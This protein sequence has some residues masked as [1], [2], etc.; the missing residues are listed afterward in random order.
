VTGNPDSSSEFRGKIIDLKKKYVSFYNLFLARERN[1]AYSSIVRVK[2]ELDVI[3]DMISH[4]ERALCKGRN[5][6]AVKSISLGE[7]HLQVVQEIGNTEQARN[8]MPLSSRSVHN[9]NDETSAK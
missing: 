5:S 4:A 1:M 9:K 7:S 3:L 8:Q 2:R 6:E